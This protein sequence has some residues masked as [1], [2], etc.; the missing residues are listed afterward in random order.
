MHST[1]GLSNLAILYLIAV[2]VIAV[3]I[4]VAIVRIKAYRDE[5]NISLIKKAIADYFH[6]SGVRVSVDCARLPGT[7]R[8]TVCIESEPMKRFRL[9]HI[10]E[11]TLRDLVHNL[12]RLEIDNIY[13][14]FPVEKS[15]QDAAAGKATQPVES[16]DEYITQGLT[17][18]HYRHLPKAEVVEASWETF[19]EANVEGSEK[20]PS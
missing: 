17:H 1:T 9:S 8:F 12:H 2:N 13:W 10:I 15:I 7:K 18:Y 19:A 6:K 4:Y 5:R 16:N 20:K 11:S 3:M 14:R